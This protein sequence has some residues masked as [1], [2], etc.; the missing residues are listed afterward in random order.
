VLEATLTEA[1]REERGDEA[2]RRLCT[3]QIGGALALM[4]GANE[5]RLSNHTRQLYRRI[6][7]AIQNRFFEHEL[8]AACVAAEVAISPRYLH[9]ILA[10][11]GTTYVQELF[12]VRLQHACTLLKDPRFAELSVSEIGWRSGFCDPSHFSRRFKA[13]FG[14]TPG[15]WRQAGQ[16]RAGVEQPLH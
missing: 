10:Q 16:W 11:E 8:D 15:Q 9:K 6:C 1:I 13:H 7:T 12:A 4:L 3:Q 5:S 14:Q 2:W